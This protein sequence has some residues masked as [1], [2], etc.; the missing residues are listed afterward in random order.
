MLTVPDI[1]DAV[2]GTVFAGLADLGERESTNRTPALTAIQRNLQREYVTHLLYILL[3]G[4]G[5]YPPTVQTLAR[6]YVRKLVSALPHPQVVEKLDT[7]T[8]AH[9][10]ECRVRLVRALEASYTLSR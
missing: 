9:L 6:H 10:E 4:D 1:F 8:A 3:E 7:Y 5:W 2:Q